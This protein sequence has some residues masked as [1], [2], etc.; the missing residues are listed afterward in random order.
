[1]GRAWRGTLRDLRPAPSGE[2]RP[3]CEQPRSHRHPPCSITGS[4][5]CLVHT[6]FRTATRTDANAMKSRCFKQSN[7]IG[8]PPAWDRVAEYPTNRHQVRGSGTILQSVDRQEDGFGSFFTGAA[9]VY[10][11]SVCLSKQT[12]LP[13]GGDGERA[14]VPKCRPSYRRA[15]GPAVCGRLCAAMTNKCFDVTEAR[16]N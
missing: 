15:L 14:Q 7:R 12:W 8:F 9:R 13:R 6:L 4:H 5:S 1:R 10:R 3:N 2:H 16:Y 11:W